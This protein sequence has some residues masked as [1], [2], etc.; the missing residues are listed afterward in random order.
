MSARDSPNMYLIPP[1][2]SSLSACAT[3]C[4]NQLIIRMDIIVQRSLFRLSRCYVMSFKELGFK[5]SPGCLFR[6]FV[7]IFNSFLYLLRFW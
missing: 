4:N 6:S 5:F 1:S 3:D 7:I 2:D